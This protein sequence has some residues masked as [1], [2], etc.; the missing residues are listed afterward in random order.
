MFLLV[1]PVSCAVIDSSDA[2]LNTTVVGSTTDEKAQTEDEELI[3]V[4]GE[5]HTMDVDGSYWFYLNIQEGQ[6]RESII[7]F[8]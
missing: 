4:D 2:S 6:P 7:I 8:P 3:T 5:E 1:E